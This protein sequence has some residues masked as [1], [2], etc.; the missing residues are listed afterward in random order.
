MVTGSEYS[1]EDRKAK[2]EKGSEKQRISD[3]VALAAFAFG[4][5]GLKTAAT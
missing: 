1:T 3:G 5:A 4:D 2:S